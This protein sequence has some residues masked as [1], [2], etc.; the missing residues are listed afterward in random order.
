MLKWSFVFLI[1]AII[2]GILGFTNIEEGAVAIAKILFFGNDAK[3]S[4]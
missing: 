1:V 4:W 2:A 3:N